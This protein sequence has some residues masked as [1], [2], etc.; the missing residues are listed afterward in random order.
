MKTILLSVLFFFNFTVFSQ[1]KIASMNECE[2]FEYLKE[3]SKNDYNNATYLSLRSDNIQRR[4]LLNRL[5]I[6]VVVLKSDTICPIYLE[7][8]TD[9]YACPEFVDEYDSIKKA[10]KKTIVN[11]NRIREDVQKGKYINIQYPLFD[12]SGLIK[13]EED[14]Y[15]EKYI[16]GFKKSYAVEFLL[17]NYKYL[18]SD[19][20]N[21]VENFDLCDSLK[22][23]SNFAHEQNL[24]KLASRIDFL[25]RQQYCF[26]ESYSSKPEIFKGVEM[27]HDNDVFMIPIFSKNQDREY[28]GGFRF[29]FA[30]DYF[31]WRFLNF[32]KKPERVLTYQTITLGGMGYTPY[33]RYR[34]NFE[35]AD[36]LHS[37][38]RPFGSYVYLERAKN[39]TWRSGLIRQ[40]GE[41]QIGAVGLSQGRKIQAKLHEDLIHKSQYV[42]GWDKQIGDGGRLAIQ[43]NQFWSFLL[44][45]CSNQ[46]RSIVKPFT[47]NVSDND[48]Y[49]GLNIIGEVD[50]RAGTFYSSAGMGIRLSTLDF[51]KQSGTNHIR[52]RKVGSNSEFGWKV[53]GGL[54]YRYVIHN[55]ILEGLGFLKPFLYDE[56]DKVNPDTY[57]LRKDQVER[58]LYIIDLGLHLRWRK[59]TVYFRQTFH[60]LEYSSPLENFDYQRADIV[61]TINPEDLQT[62][63]NEMVKENQSFVNSKNWFGGK[64]VYGYG[65]L[66]VSWIIE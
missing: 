16:S 32:T 5:E 24:E 14:E 31:K 11:N 42:Y 64:T 46:S 61:G 38:D 51:L 39:R 21:T 8:K 44:Y 33:I 1:V 3:I 40:R 6:Y 65:T 62:Y 26:Y 54:S 37:Y 55:A 7:N 45:S 4:D 36:S 23:M 10:C 19:T 17:H 30:T 18:K 58:N 34:N 20:C 48:K 60:T 13:E 41:F 50:I 29:S 66:G 27:H 28:T 59:T 63:N 25:D 47:S 12:L 49:A 15:V 9:K 57:V 43:A 56:Y 53:D 2:L 22:N 52:S 35:L